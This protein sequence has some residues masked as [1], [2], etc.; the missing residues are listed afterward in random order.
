[1]ADE[2]PTLPFEVFSLL[3][4]PHAAA[5]YSREYVKQLGPQPGDTPFGDAVR[6][7]VWGDTTPEA[8]QAAARSRPEQLNAHYLIGLQRLSLGDRSGAVEHFAAVEE[9]G[10]ILSTPYWPHL[11]LKRLRD[12]PAWPPWIK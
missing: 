4:Q 9:A 6:A 7:Y 2:M 12:D 1:M 10:F 11:L 5:R 8:L 3:G